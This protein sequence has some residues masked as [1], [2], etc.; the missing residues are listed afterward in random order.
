MK[1]SG[2]LILLIMPKLRKNKFKN[3]EKNYFYIIGAFHSN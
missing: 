3:K 1:K 2:K